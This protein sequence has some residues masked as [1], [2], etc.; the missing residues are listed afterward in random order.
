M[1]HVILRHKSNSISIDQIRAGARRPSFKLC[2]S[3]QVRIGMSH[4][5][6]TLLAK[7]GAAKNEE[8][9]LHLVIHTGNYQME[10]PN[11]IVGMMVQHV[12]QMMLLY[13][14]LY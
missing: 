1:K 13:S 11:D 4:L 9:K 7:V 6:R 14:F 3:T 2:P 8:F 12:I 10:I 5:I